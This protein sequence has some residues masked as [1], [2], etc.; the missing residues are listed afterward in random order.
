MSHWYSIT[1]DRSREW[2]GDNSMRE[3]RKDFKQPNLT[4]YQIV[5]LLLL[6]LIIIIIITMII[7]ILMIHI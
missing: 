1:S 4:G 3:G 6:L 5:L 7:I 2:V